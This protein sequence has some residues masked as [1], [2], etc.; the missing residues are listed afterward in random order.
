MENSTV[1][2]FIRPGEILLEI[3]NENAG[4]CTR[5]DKQLATGKFCWDHRVTSDWV[6]GGEPFEIGEEWFPDARHADGT[7]CGIDSRGEAIYHCYAK[8]TCSECGAIDQSD[9]K[10]EAYGDRITCKACGDSKWYSIGD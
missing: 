10:Q 2:L 8:P 7:T 5:C 6:F 4:I 9:L 3:V 1:K